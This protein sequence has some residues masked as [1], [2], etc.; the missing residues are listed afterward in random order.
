[1]HP[2]PADRSGQSVK[3]D[4]AKYVTHHDAEGIGAFLDDD[5]DDLT[6]VLS[7]TIDYLAGPRR[8][9]T[10]GP[11]YVSIAVARGTCVPGVPGVLGVLGASMPLPASQWGA[12]LDGG[13]PPSRLPH[14]YA[15]PH[16]DCTGATIVLPI[17]SWE[18]RFIWERQFIDMAGNDDSSQPEGDDSGQA[19]G[20]NSSQ[21]EGDDSELGGGEGGSANGFYGMMLMSSTHHRYAGLFTIRKPG[22]P[23]VTQLLVRGSLA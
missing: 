2:C 15:P 22:A 17:A 14:M 5:F 10:V 4:A 8:T 18:R 3:T 12:R 21:P 1:M 7:F 16:D 9:L 20:D 19:E 6:S 23:P 11:V 13:L